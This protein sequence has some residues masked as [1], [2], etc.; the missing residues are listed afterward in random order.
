MRLT[1]KKHERFMLRV[2]AEAVVLNLM[3]FHGVARK[4]AR[5]KVRVYEV[6]VSYSGRSYAEGKKIGWRDGFRALYCI[7][8]DSFFK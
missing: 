6:G 5:K 2:Y 3:N 8:T 7:V 4:V 1:G